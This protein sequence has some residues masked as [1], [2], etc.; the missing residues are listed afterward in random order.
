MAE[1]LKAVD[2]I[3][4]KTITTQTNHRQHIHYWRICQRCRLRQLVHTS[5]QTM[6][7]LKTKSNLWRYYYG[8]SKQNL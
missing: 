5:L 4:K 2:T 7:L 8:N 3:V 1:Y 6:G